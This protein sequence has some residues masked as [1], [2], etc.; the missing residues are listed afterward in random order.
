[1]NNFHFTL[2]IHSL[3][4]RWQIFWHPPPP[5]RKSMADFLQNITRRSHA[6]W[7]LIWSHYWWRRIIIYSPVVNHHRDWKTAWKMPRNIMVLNM[8]SDWIF[9]YCYPFTSTIFY[10]WSIYPWFVFKWF[11]HYCLKMLSKIYAL[12]P[13]KDATRMQWGWKEDQDATRLR[14]SRT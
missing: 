14:I 5:A 10:F 3:C 13:Q 12:F 2:L 9:I 4:S 1:M 11:T 6:V 7:Q 8:L